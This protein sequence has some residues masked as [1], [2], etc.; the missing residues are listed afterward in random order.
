MIQRQVSTIGC[1]I[2]I[3]GTELSLNFIKKKKLLLSV[4]NIL[5][6]KKKT[7][8]QWNFVEDNSSLKYVQRGM[9]GISKPFL[10]G[11]WSVQKCHLL[12]TILSEL[13]KQ[14]ISC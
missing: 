5:V 11:S 4:F 6:I 1:G 13:Q 14:V 12:D 9:I 8:K 7:K 2:I 10:L 3:C